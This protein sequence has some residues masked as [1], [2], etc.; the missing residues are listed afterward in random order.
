M[1]A[2]QTAGNPARQHA[3]CWDRP[4]MQHQRKGPDEPSGTARLGPRSNL[5]PALFHEVL[6]EL[7]TSRTSSTQPL[8]QH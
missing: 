4:K 2:L 3:R 8:Q 7:T 1:A 6:L 5:S